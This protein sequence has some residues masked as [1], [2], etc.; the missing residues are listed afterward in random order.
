MMSFSQY[1]QAT[2]RSHFF[3][4]VDRLGV[5]NLAA[6]G[7]NSYRSYLRGL[8]SAYARAEALVAAHRYA[9]VAA[10]FRKLLEAPRGCGRLSSLEP[11]RPLRGLQFRCGP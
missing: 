5:D 3:E 11:E 9:E 6:N 10:E 7:L 2:V 4:G 1:L 8:Q